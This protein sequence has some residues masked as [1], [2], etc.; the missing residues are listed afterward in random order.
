MDDKQQT[1]ERWPLSFAQQRLWFL[2]RLAPGNPFYNLPIAA[3]MQGQLDV[4][5]LGNAAYGVG[6]PA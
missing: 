4:A 6:G 2:N 1:V 3:R 5:A